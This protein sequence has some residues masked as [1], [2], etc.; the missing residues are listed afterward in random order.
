[1][2]AGARVLD[3]IRKEQLWS[4]LDQGFLSEIPGKL[5]VQLKT[6][7]DLVVYSQLRPFS[8]ARIAEIGGG[9]SRILPQ[10]AKTNQ[11]WNI[12]P[13]EGDD[14]GPADER[15]IAGVTNIKT[16]VGRFDPALSSGF[17][18]CLFSVS[19]VEH[20]ENDELESFFADCVRIL[21]PGGVAYHAID[22]YLSDA[23]GDHSSEYAQKRFDLYLKAVRDSRVEPLG[24][25]YAGPLRFSTNMASNPDFIMHGWKGLSPS[26]DHLRMRAQSVSLI[27]GLRKI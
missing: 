1:M 22:M 20:V 27:M 9:E 10:L 13:F 18:D 12:E 6:T 4:T 7:Q 8:G 14:N 5:S 23:D 16:E 17:F 2:D 25:V 3:F 15:V 26:L 11:C 24:A 21:R 19:V